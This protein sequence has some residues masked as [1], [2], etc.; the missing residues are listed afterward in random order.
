M[1]VLV[2]ALARDYPMDHEVVVYQ[3]D[4]TKKEIPM[5]D[6][7]DMLERMGSDAGLRDA[8]RQDLERVLNAG[9]INE[10]LR[11]AILSGDRAEFQ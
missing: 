1:H 6:V 9:Q 4:I 8:S 2:D 3:P 11:E 5:T 10:P 7:I